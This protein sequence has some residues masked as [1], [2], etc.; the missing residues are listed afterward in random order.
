MVVTV[1]A[2]GANVHG[3]VVES[4]Y[5]V[6]QAMMGFGGD[7]VGLDQAKGAVDDDARF[8]SDTV[9]YPAQTQVLYISHTGH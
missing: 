3:D 7:V 5:V 1:I 8:G 2:A 6:E 9:A 4:W